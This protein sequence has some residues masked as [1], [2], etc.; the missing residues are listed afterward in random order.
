MSYSIVPVVLEL[1]LDVSDVSE[2]KLLDDKLLSAQDV[3]KRLQEV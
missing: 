3:I 2:F 1:E